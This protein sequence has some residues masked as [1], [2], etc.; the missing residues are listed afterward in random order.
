MGEKT[1]GEVT[2]ISSLVSS[3]IQPLIPFKNK[4]LLSCSSFAVVSLGGLEGGD[5]T[6]KS[7]Q[8]FRAVREGD[9]RGKP[10]DS[11]P[12]FLKGVRCQKTL[13]HGKEKIQTDSQDGDRKC[14]S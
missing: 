10:W 2:S 8:K 6:G 9:Y 4:M 3:L 1:D 12:F 11:F 5:N 7:L 14:A 13:Q